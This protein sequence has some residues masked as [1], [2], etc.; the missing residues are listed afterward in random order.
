MQTPLQAELF[1]V[2]YFAKEQKKAM[3]INKSA[4]YLQRNQLLLC[5]NEKPHSNNEKKRYNKH[6]YK[7]HIDSCPIFRR[8]TLIAEP[9]GQ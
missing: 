9:S 3:Q 6:T 1:S 5:T 8:H 2:N 7:L 4:C